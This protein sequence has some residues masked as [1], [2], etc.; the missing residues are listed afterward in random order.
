M[1]LPRLLG[2][3]GRLGDLS[4]K[5]IGAIQR[6]VDDVGT[7][8]YVVGSSMNKGRRNARS[9]LPLGKGPGTKSDIDYTVLDEAAKFEWKYPSNYAWQRLPEVGWHGPLVGAPK[10]PA[11]LFRPGQSPIKLR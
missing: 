9:H 2:G 5:E 1:P 6:L 4:R 3:A 10:G 8:L 11:V 7:D